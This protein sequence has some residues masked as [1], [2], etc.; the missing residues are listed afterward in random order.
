MFN[1]HKNWYTYRFSKTTYTVV[2]TMFPILFFIVQNKFSGYFMLNYNLCPNYL[3]YEN[4]QA[5]HRY[6]KRTA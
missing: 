3:A 2:R 6:L 5:K 4:S 1:C